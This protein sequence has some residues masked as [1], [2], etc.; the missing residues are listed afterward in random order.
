MEHGYEM[1]LKLLLKNVKLCS[2]YAHTFVYL[3]I[4]QPYSVLK[5]PMLCLV[6]N[7]QRLIVVFRSTRF[8]EKSAPMTS[9]GRSY[10][11]N[12]TTK[13][14]KTSSTSPRR[15]AGSIYSSPTNCIS[16]YGCKVSYIS[17]RFMMQ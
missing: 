16:G 11:S 14:Q 17:K 3:S 7:L 6:V 15:K 13:S 10:S 5:A 8:S 12:T 2:L 9:S 1:F 4:L